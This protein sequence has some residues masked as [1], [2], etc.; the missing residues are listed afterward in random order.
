VASEGGDSLVVCGVKGE[1]DRVVAATLVL[2]G[3][4]QDANRRIYARE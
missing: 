4:G 2:V 1:G 3:I